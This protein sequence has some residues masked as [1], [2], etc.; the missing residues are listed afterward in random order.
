M[1][2]SHVESTSSST[3]SRSRG[4]ESARGGRGRGR[5]GRGGRSGGRNQEAENKKTVEDAEVGEKR[6]RAVEPAGGPDAGLRGKEAGIPV[7]FSAKKVK[8]GDK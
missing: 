5:G 3:N 4:R 6:K 1:A 2:L 8:T 7:V